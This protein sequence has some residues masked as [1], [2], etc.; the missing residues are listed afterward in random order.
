M[1]LSYWE[2]AHLFSRA[3]FGAT[4][5]EV[6]AHR[7]R[8]WTQL[9]DLVLD[10]DRTPG[11]EPAPNLAPGRDWYAKHVDMTY[12]WLERARRPVTEAP[13]QEKMTLFWHGLL[14]SGL[15]KV[16]D[17]K[18][19]FNQNQLFRR[20]GMGNTRNLLWLTSID[21]AMLR[22]LDNHENTV[23]ELNENFARE[24]LEL[25]TL[26]VGNYSEADVRESARAWTGHGLDANGKYQFRASAHDSGSKTFLGQRGRW[27]GRDIINLLL[28]HRR[29]V[30]ARFLCHRLWSFFAYPVS[31]DDQVV[32]DIM[33]TYRPRLEITPTLRA[34]FMHPAFRSTRARRGLVRSPIE[35]AVA[36]MR[37][38]GLSCDEARPEWYLG[39]MGQQPFE[40][41]NVSGWRQNEFWISE[42]ALWSKALMASHVRW[43]VAGRNDLHD[44]ADV[45]SWSPKR[46]F[47]YSTTD[48]VDMALANYGLRLQS[49]QSRQVLVNYVRTERADVSSWGQRY[50]L[51]M[52]PLLS[53]EMQMA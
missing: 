48:V 44:V 26:G 1:T 12:Y 7:R 51:L 45:V 15:L 16:G 4:E 53:P 29:E 24:L 14:C 3:G 6:L 28:N 27:K 2:V 35:F 34:I 9:V 18:M 41:P 32:A 5:A 40:P 31:P 49:K 13:I 47:K 43:K 10:V 52:L 20:H 11:L 46:V 21:P 33:A 36:V 50:G 8:S 23:G 39:T 17:H 30:H 42:S 19:M 37:H 22:Y 25:F 38:T